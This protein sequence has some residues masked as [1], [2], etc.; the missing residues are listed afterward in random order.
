MRSFVGKWESKFYSLNTNDLDVAA[1]Y[2]LN[3][4][5]VDDNENI[6]E[7]NNKKNNVNKNKTTSIKNN[8]KHDNNFKQKGKP[9]NNNEEEKDDGGN[10]DEDEKVASNANDDMTRRGSDEKVSRDNIDD[11]IVSDNSGV[12]G[13]ASSTGL[14]NPASLEDRNK[15]QPEIETFRPTPTHFTK[16][17]LAC[18]L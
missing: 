9:Q 16:V 15:N 3:N 12:K 18:C 1:K 7:G 11:S 10:Y 2:L 13:N 14:G 8:E 5:L 17:C 6:N 4:K